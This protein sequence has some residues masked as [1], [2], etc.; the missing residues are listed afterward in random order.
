MRSRIVVQSVMDCRAGR[1]GA[2]DKDKKPKNHA[3]NWA[4]RSFCHLVL[5]VH[6]DLFKPAPC[7]RQE[8]FFL[9]QKA[10]KHQRPQHCLYF[11]P[12]PQGHGSLRPTFGPVRTGLAFSMAA[13]ASL[14]TSLGFCW[15]WEEPVL[16]PP[17]PKALV[18]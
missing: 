16:V 8:L 11:L 3:Q 6:T 15:A 1:K 9:N 14:T 2:K 4:G 7:H 13:A 12:L 10:A 17:P 5:P 18:D